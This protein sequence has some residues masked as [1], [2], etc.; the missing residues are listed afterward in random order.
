MTIPLLAITE[1]LD[2][3]TKSV[4]SST[5]DLKQN[6]DEVHASDTLHKQ[7]PFSR[8]VWSNIRRACQ[9]VPIIDGLVHR[10]LLDIADHI[11]VFI[12]TWT[13]F[14]IY[15]TPYDM[16]IRGPIILPSFVAMG[17]CTVFRPLYS[18]MIQGS[19]CCCVLSLIVY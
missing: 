3:R 15:L 17:Y 8:S 18:G 13:T 2:H 14:S 4:A 9:R 12:V 19:V 16:P 10:L 11:V 5:I 6:H 7:S 1:G